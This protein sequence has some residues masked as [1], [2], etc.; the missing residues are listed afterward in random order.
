MPLC[1]RLVR[2]GPG[3]PPA[4]A[5]EPAADLPSPAADAT[6]TCIRQVE[7]SGAL[8]KALA[9]VDGFACEDLLQS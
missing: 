7:G 2:K 8:A 1:F 9:V 3:A 5:A 4:A 6:W